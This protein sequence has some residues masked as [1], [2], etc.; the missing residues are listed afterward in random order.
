MKPILSKKQ[1]LW[2]DSRGG[3]NEA[4]VLID[5]NGMYVPM[6]SPSG[7]IKIY[8]PDDSKMRI[9]KDKFSKFETVIMLTTS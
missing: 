2:L 1:C 6:S 5:R 7:T 3:R 9:K 8:V 4:D